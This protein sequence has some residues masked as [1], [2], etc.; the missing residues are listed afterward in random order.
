MTN[1]QA[2][3]NVTRNKKTKSRGKKISYYIMGIGVF[4]VLMTIVYNYMRLTEL[5]SE[6]SGLK[7]QIEKLESEE[8]GLNAKIEKMYNLAEVEQRAK[9]AGMIKL[10]PEQIEYVELKNADMVTISKNEKEVSPLIETALK[11]FNIVVEYLN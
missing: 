5:T 8:N 9:A 6:T 4:F 10:D 1:T 3:P 11:S 7:K 2:M